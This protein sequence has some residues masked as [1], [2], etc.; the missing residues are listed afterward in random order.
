MSGPF[1]V[2]LSGDFKKPDGSPTY[3]DFDLAP[4]RAAPNVE[5]AF[6]DVANPL[7]AE[8]LE[9]FDALILLTHRFGRESVPKSGRLAVIA[10]FG[11]GYDTVDVPACT[12]AGIALVITPDGVRRPVAVSIL[13]LMLA[14][15]GKMMVKDRLTREGPTGFAQR[16]DHMGVGLVGRTLGSVGIGNIG[17]EFFR[18]A[19]PLD[20]RFIAHDPFADKAVAAEL[21]IELVSLEEVFRQSDV[22]SVSCPL[23]PETHHLVNAER[24][25]LMKPTAYLI[26]TARGPIVDQKALTKVLAERR[27]A[28]AGLDVLEQEP[29][30]ADDP[31]LKLDNVILA[32]HALCWTDQCFAGNGAADVK[33]VLEV[34]HGR[35]PRGVVNRAVLETATW[36]RRLADF[37]GRFGD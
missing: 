24:L 6:L 27:I 31:I 37:H 25:A 3:P 18:I 32:P 33:A 17:A 36:K 34:Q 7:R 14:L 13:A 8:Q 1:R 16:S 20:M 35:V 11:V 19:K 4:L 29:P 10:R 12:D 28:G 15:T 23:T 30:D 21:G 9:D 22:L 2:A 5:V 26:N